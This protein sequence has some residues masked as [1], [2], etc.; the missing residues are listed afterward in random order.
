LRSLQTPHSLP[1]YILRWWHLEPG[2]AEE[3]E[4]VKYLIEKYGKSRGFP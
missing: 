3:E 4:Y 1:S 2:S